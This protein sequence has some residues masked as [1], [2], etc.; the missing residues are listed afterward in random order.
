MQQQQQPLQ[1]Q[2][3][4]DPGI[5][6][7]AD[8]DKEPRTRN[9]VTTAEVGTQAATASSEWTEWDLGRALPLLRSGSPGVVRRTLRN[10]HIRLWH[11][12]SARL[13]D[14]L[15]VAGAPSSVLDQVQS[16]V[17]TCRV[18]RSWQ[19]VAPRAVASSSLTAHF[20]E[21]MQVDLLFWKTHVVLHMIDVCLRFAVATIIANRTTEVVLEAITKLV[22]V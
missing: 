6:A 1:Q 5:G 4:G 18:C 11:C 7:Q 9:R 2:V 15:T 12:P 20:N 8:K 17:D 10:I 19:D 22:L 16:V 21:D 3:A 14:L 13:R